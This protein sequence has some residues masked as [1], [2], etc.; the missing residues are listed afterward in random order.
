MT[1][2]VDQSTLR[3]GDVVRIPKDINNTGWH[4]ECAGD[5]L[6]IVSVNEYGIPFYQDPRRDQPLEFHCPVELVRRA[7]DPASFV[8]GTSVAY[9][10]GNSTSKGVIVAVFRTLAGALRFA[11]EQSDGFIFVCGEEPLMR[12][13]LQASTQPHT[14]TPE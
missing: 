14:S 13:E 7:G 5:E 4:L 2:Y 9:A 10:R 12:D 3:V 8:V 11:I 6:H 1:K